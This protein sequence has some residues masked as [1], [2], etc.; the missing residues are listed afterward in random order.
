[1]GS[2]LSPVFTG[3]SSYAST[4]QQVIT[5]SVRIA[6]LPLQQLQNRLQDLNGES[7]ALQGLDQDFGALQSALDAIHASL[8]SASYSASSSDPGAV[9]A[10]AGAGALEASYTL[11][12]TDIGPYSNTISDSNLPGVSDPTTSSFSDSTDYTLTIDGQTFDIQPSDGS[13]NALARAINESSADVEASLVN[14]GSSSAPQYR[15]VVRSSDLGPVSIQLNDG[16]R[17]LLTGVHTGSLASY[18]VNG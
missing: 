16:A 10:N 1:M 5:R 8:G 2:I 6:A 13:L 12:I 9:T 17:D 3:V 14:T 18:T 4:L 15:L 11:D 7:A